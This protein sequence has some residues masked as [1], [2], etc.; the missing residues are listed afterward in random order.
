MCFV[1]NGGPSFGTSTFKTLAP[2]LLPCSTC[3]WRDVAASFDVS[4]T[5]FS[6]VG[7][8]LQTWVWVA[9]MSHSQAAASFNGVDRDVVHSAAFVTNHLFPHCSMLSGTVRLA[10]CDVKPASLIQLQTTEPARGSRVLSTAG[11]T[12]C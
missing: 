5:V 12:S 6:R 8:D 4:H 2:V 3:I 11:S 1:M 10:S 9:F 7:A